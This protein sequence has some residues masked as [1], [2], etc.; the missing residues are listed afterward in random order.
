M[1]EKIIKVSVN[2]YGIHPLHWVILPG[3]TWQCGSNYT[4]VNLQTLQDKELI[5]LLENIIRGGISS[6]MRDRYV[7]VD[8]NKTILYED[9]NKLYRWAMSA[10]LPYDEIKFEN[11][12]KLEDIINTPDD[13]DI[14]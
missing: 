14:G 5:L 13:S 9:A 3:Y 2:E 12:P 6:V 10:Y 7:K 1:F 8:E 11:N 4:G